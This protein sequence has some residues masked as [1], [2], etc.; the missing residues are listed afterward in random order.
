MRRSL[1]ALAVAVAAATLASGCGGGGDDDEAEAS[2][3]TTTT[4]GDVD[5]ST[6]DAVVAAL[7]DAGIPCTDL[8]PRGTQELAEYGIE[9]T[10]SDCLVGGDRL[11]IVVIDSDDELSEMHKLLTDLV[12][13]ATDDDG[14]PLDEILWVEVDRTIVAYD[15]PSA[16]NATRLAPI[17]KALGGKLEKVT[18]VD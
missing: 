7:A 5:V 11:G 17:Q 15:A 2:G 6:P 16:N 14:Q 9:G 10:Q 18:A 12:G 1:A 3:S 13:V 4:V 8:V